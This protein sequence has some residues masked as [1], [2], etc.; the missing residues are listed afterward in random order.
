ML[1][2]QHGSVSQVLGRHRTAR[3]SG[4][5]PWVERFQEPRHDL[6]GTAIGLPI[7]PGVVLGV[8]V[9][10]YV[11]CLGLRVWRTSSFFPAGAPPATQ[12]MTRGGRGCFQQREPPESVCYFF[13][14][15]ELGGAGRVF[16]RFIHLNSLHNLLQLA[17]QCWASTLKKYHQ[18][19]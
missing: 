7:R 6:S 1:G 13:L 16:I 14:W 9:G 18:T 8:N 5:P 11:E 12:K 19:P 17:Q 3:V 2:P 4:G 15:G 10:A